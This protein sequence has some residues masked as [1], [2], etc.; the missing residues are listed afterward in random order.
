MFT[1][2]DTSSDFYKNL[3]STEIEKKL[4]AIEN[5]EKFVDK[6]SEKKKMTNE[7]A[8]TYLKTNLDDKEKIARNLRLCGTTL[9][10]AREIGDGTMHLIGGYF[11]QKRLCPMCAFRRSLKTCYNIISIIQE[12]EF[13]NLEWVFQTF[14]IKNC[15]PED[16]KLT[17]KRLLNAF[18]RMTDN[19]NSAYNKQFVGWFRS[20]EVTYNAEDNTYHP[21]LH[22]LACVKKDYFKKTNGGYFSQDK[23]QKHWK[24]FLNK[25]TYTETVK[26]RLV[27]NGHE[28]IVVPEKAVRKFEPIDYFPVCH[29][30]KVYGE[31]YQ[32]IAEV[33]KYTVKA[34]DYSGNPEVLERLTVDLERVRCTAMGG[35]IKQVAQ[36]LKL[37]D[38]ELAGL[39]DTKS[40]REK[41]IDNPAFTLMLLKWNSGAK[42]YEIVQVKKQQ[43]GSKGVT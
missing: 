5:S 21:H 20:L 11:C 4:K 35:I 27:T 18:A 6:Y 12:P 24:K 43:C 19:K 25:A 42:I 14:T 29:I 13:Q 16:L 28:L 1:S 3:S 31:E 8:A 39:D 36:R 40:F 22:V 7:T 32:S 9:E 34:V 2:S 15:K 38:N 26:K 17:I 10:F 30:E 41:L 23:L 37:E 33:S